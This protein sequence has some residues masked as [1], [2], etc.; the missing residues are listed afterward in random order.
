MFKL[1]SLDTHVACSFI[2]PEKYLFCPDSPSPCTTDSFYADHF[3]GLVFGLAILSISTYLQLSFVIACKN[4]QH[5]Q[6]EWPT[7][8]GCCHGRLFCRFTPPL[9]RPYPYFSLPSMLKKPFKLLFPRT[10]LTNAMQYLL[11][12]HFPK[13]GK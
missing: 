1:W 4:L 7:D 10:C 2:N 6:I 11:I 3:L 12:T 13:F 9:V 5:K 8:F